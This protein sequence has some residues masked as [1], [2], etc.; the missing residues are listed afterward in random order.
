MKELVKLEFATCAKEKRNLERSRK[1]KP[2]TDAPK[3]PRGRPRKN[4]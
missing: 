3:R 4:P 1:E 2:V